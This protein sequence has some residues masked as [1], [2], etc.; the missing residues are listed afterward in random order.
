M[1]GCGA[2]AIFFGPRAAG[3]IRGTPYKLLG[4]SLFG[5]PQVGLFNTFLTLLLKAPAPREPSYAE[6]TA[7]RT[8]AR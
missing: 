5:L 7:A 4:A 1:A 8:A 2:G 3:L 6:R